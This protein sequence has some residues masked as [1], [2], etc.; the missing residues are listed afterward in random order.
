MEWVFDGEIF[1]WRGPAP[2]F[3]VAMP[4]SDSAELK[5]EARSL[6]YWGQIP[7]HVVIGDTAFRTALFPKNGR[8]LVPLKDAVRSAAGIGEGDLITVAL[9]PAWPSDDAPG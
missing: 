7:V 9:R 4:E 6:I 2:F 8:Y 3:F 5:D 1:E